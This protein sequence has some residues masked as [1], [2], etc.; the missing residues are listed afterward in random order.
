MLEYLQQHDERE[1]AL[2]FASL[3]HWVTVTGRSFGLDLDGEQLKRAMLGLNE[4]QHSLSGSLLVLLSK[5]EFNLEFAAGAF[6]DKASGY[7]ISGPVEHIV[8]TVLD[9]LSK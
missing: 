1:R 5:Q 2:L 6:L 4:V 9:R 3:I 7:G 8:H